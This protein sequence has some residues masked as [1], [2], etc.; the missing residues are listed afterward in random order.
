MS[1]SEVEHFT[2]GE[3]IGVDVAAIE[4]DLAALWRESASGEHG[5]TRACLWNLVLHARGEAELVVGK[6][7]VDAIAAAC[8]ARS[9]VLDM[10]AEAAAGERDLEAWI[11]AN[12]Q[13]APGGGKLLCSEEITIA[14]RA[15][16]RARV[17]ALVRALL[18]PDVPTAALWLGPAPGVDDARAL[19]ALTEVAQRLVIDS[20]DAAAPPGGRPVG[21]RAGSWRTLLGAAGLVQVTDLGWLRLSAFRVLLASCFDPPVGA[22]GLLRVKRAAVVVSPRGVATGELLLGWLA[23]R[24]GWGEARRAGQDEVVAGGGAGAGAGAGGGRR[25]WR[26]ARVAG[27]VELGLEVRDV[28]AGRDG[29]W[30]IVIECEEGPTCR[31]VDVE[32]EAA[33]TVRIEMDGLPTRV[34]MCEP[35]PDA[36]LLVA[37]LGA[38]G[39]D[40]LYVQAMARAAELEA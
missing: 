25:E 18:V 35:R 14:A 33:G 2:H 32:G 12:C 9:L 29:I 10:R 6:G 17:P 3:A 22:D 13:V 34:V 39:L 4:R 30:E 38:R 28:A 24:L 36:E 15:A 26:A 37:A 21:W 20:D 1:A 19:A 23:T 31:V 7:L 40:P 5:V 16:A 8:P 27:Q 11:S